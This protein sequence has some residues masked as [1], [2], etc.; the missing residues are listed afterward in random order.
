MDRYGLLSLGVTRENTLSRLNLTLF[1][2]PLCALTLGGCATTSGTGST[3]D[4]EWAWDIFY[5][6][7]KEVT[8]CRGVQ[9]LQVTDASYCA[10]KPVND[11][12]WPGPFQK[13]Q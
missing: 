6:S 12:R 3:A 8:A 7:A 9:T 11:N 10:G 13:P 2:V 5:K 4:R 1:V